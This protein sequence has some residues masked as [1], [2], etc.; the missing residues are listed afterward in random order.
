MDRDETEW[1][2]VAWGLFCFVFPSSLGQNLSAVGILVVFEAVLVPMSE[3][4]VMS[5]AQALVSCMNAS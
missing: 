3:R 1:G 2:A 5:V 4:R